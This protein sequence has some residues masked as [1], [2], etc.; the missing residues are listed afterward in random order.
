MQ[1]GSEGDHEELER[2]KTDSETPNGRTDSASNLASGSRIPSL[3]GARAISIIFVVTAHLATSG[4][5]PFAQRLWRLDVGNL[6]VRVFFVISGFLIT[7]L[8]IEE[9]ARTG[10]ISL[11]NF[12]LRRFFRIV[13]AYWLFLLTVATLVP[14]GTVSATY[15][16]IL[17]ATLYVSNYAIPGFAVGHTWS[18]SVEEQFYLLWPLALIALGIRRAL[19]IAA[20]VLIISPAFRAADDLGLWHTHARYAFETV[21]DALATGCL[22]AG[23]RDR[24]WKLS[25]YRSLLSSRIFLLLPFAVI[26]AM[27][28][29]GETIL[30]DCLGISVLNACVAITLDRYMR[31]R[32]SIGGKLLNWSP[33]VWIGMLSYSIYLWQQLF[34]DDSH[35]LGFPLNLFCIAVCAMTSYFLVEA[36]MLKVGKKLRTS[37]S[38]KQKGDHVVSALLP[39]DRNTNDAVRKS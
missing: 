37:N 23:W 18:L 22:L 34:L 21:A 14:T 36:P 7:S 28:F 4:T 11:R 13:P 5:F 38:N 30:W 29:G 8:L 10:D 6:G 19:F 20:L 17:K 33:L 24:L 9:S 3:D 1:N 39:P 27:A 32:D 35:S 31:F 16:D 15:P 25:S 2:A 26:I 12:Y